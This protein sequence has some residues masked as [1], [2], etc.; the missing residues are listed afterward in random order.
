MKP[1]FNLCDMALISASQDIWGINVNL[2]SSS[3]Y[4]PW[5]ILK[6]FLLLPALK[7]N[8]WDEHMSEW[9]IAL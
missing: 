5:N 3:A 1:G 6:G 4:F 9:Y 7:G 8:Q 2:T